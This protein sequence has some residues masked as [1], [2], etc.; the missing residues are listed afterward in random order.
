MIVARSD[1]EKAVSFKLR[2]LTVT[3]ISATGS[4]ESTVPNMLP[5]RSHF[6][7]LRALHSTLDAESTSPLVSRTSTLVVY[8]GVAFALVCVK[9]SLSL[10]VF[11]AI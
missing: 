7:E 2:V 5:S 1:P 10:A 11:K 9:D 8:V 3:G 4:L 6:S